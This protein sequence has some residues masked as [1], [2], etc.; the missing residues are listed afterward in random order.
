MHC[1]CY[2][3]E[4]EEQ[5]HRLEPFTLFKSMSGG[6]EHLKKKKKTLKCSTYLQVSQNRVFVGAWEE[7][8]HGVGPVVQEGDSCTIQIT[9]QLMDV[10]LEL[11]KS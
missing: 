1:H 5:V 4:T 2:L 6:N 7:D 10:C 3:I 11:C 9:G 8:P